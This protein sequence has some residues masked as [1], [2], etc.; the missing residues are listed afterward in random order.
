MAKLRVHRAAN[1]EITLISDLTTKHLKSIISLHYRMIKG[2]GLRVKNKVGP[3][4]YSDAYANSEQTEQILGTKH[5]V[6][7]LNNRINVEHQ[8]EEC[9]APRQRGD[10]YCTYC[11]CQQ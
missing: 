9:D 10:N 3:G 6:R 4:I 7:E 11:G 1:G 5:Y 2:N 8:C